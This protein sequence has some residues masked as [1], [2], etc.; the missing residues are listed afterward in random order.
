MTGGVVPVIRG[1]RRYEGGAGGV[2]V[3]PGEEPEDFRSRKEIFQR[4]ESV[5]SVEMR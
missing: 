3:A 5:Q 1:E 2:V 4:A